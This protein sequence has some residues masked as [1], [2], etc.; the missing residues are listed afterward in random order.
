MTI[1]KVAVPQVAYAF[2]YGQI[3]AML[4]RERKV[5]APELTDFSDF[6]IITLIERA[7]ALVGH[8]NNIGVDLLANESFLRT[9]VMARSVSDLLA[10]IGYAMLP[11]S[12]AVAPM[13]Y[14][15]NKIITTTTTIVPTGSLVSTDGTERVFFE[16]V[17][18]DIEIDQSAVCHHVFAYE[19]IGGTETWTDHTAKAIVTADP[20]VAW[21][22]VAP[23][24]A[25]YFGF[26][27]YMPTAIATTIN[28][29]G[30]LYRGV[31]EYSNTD[32]AK[33]QPDEV[34][35]NG[36][37]LVMDLTTYLGTT[38]V[39]GSVVR[40]KC[41]STGLYE[42]TTVYWTDRNAVSVGILGQ[43]NP[44]EEPGDY[45]IGAYWEPAA[46]VANPAPQLGVEAEAEWI[47][48]QTTVNNW[49][50]TEVNSAT[51]YW[52]RFR[53]V[54]VIGGAT[55][56]TMEFIDPTVGGQWVAGEVR[57]GQ[58]T[59]ES[60]GVTNGEPNQ[61][62]VCSQPHYLADSM[63]LLVG[64]DEWKA[65]TSF[66]SSAATD[67]HYRVSIGDEDTP[68]I[69]FG[70]GTNGHVPAP[71]QT[72]VATYRF[73]G[74]ID[75]NVGSD[76][77]TRDRG[78]LT[79]ISDVT[80][81]RQ[82]SGWS[83]SQA[84]TALGRESAKVAGVAA[85]RHRGVALNKSD[86]PPMA[87]DYTDN[88]GTR[89]FSRAYA[90]EGTYGEKTIEVV[91]VA[92]GGA[93]PT[94]P[95][96]EALATYFNGDDNATP[97]LPKRVVANQMVVATSWIPRIININI[98]VWGPVTKEQIAAQLRQFIDPEARELTHEPDEI[99]VLTYKV[100]PR[101][102]WEFGNEVPL[103]AIHSIVHSVSPS[104]RKVEIVEPTGNVVLASRELPVLGTLVVEVYQ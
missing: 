17:D 5:R 23:N 40:V 41:H 21:A 30:A 65:V 48:P 63:V 87:R 26:V 69:V 52:M 6:S 72:I 55:S 16:R 103:S 61:S 76:T 4:Q 83:Q 62:V 12:P 50:P 7:F 100:T 71:G 74:E 9:A 104:V 34:A 93:V 15:L 88:D 29:A 95:Q 70:D 86:V 96:L 101:W 98:K 39:A 81:P 1:T 80:N 11:A 53:V 75:G 19:V 89:P 43:V 90:Y 79:K 10:A 8:L 67:K 45:A 102:Q 28:T 20:W 22:S 47:L 37:A 57:Q 92:A 42:E 64:G 49:Q 31:W 33:A 38:N 78:G 36:V 32:L 73:G 82:A 66:L 27:G 85:L 2:Y 77:I 46:M 59:T 56:P 84:A 51:A 44:S 68:T 91:V 54:T 94:T 18:D 24:H 60:L 97:P 13:I 99:G 14:R 58:T 3:V 25:V 35:Y